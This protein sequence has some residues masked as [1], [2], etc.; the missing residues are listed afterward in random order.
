ME[1]HREE[2]VHKSD[3]KLVYEFLGLP[4]SYTCL[5]LVLIMDQEIENER[6]SYHPGLRLATVLCKGE[7]DLKSTAKT[8]KTG[9]P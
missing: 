6:R 5:K 3:V 1:E 8:L 9:L 4:P 7:A 2:R